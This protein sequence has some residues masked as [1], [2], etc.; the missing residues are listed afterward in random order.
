[1]I[2]TGE[3]ILGIIVSVFAVYQSHVEAVRRKLER[4]PTVGSCSVMLR[5]RVK[6]RRWREITIS[7]I[8]LEK[9]GHTLQKNMSISL[10]NKPLSDP[11][12]EDQEE[13]L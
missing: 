2:L 5:Q 13:M 6:R 12:L 3:K 4:K 11:P 8:K 9:T 7:R 1:M 10:L